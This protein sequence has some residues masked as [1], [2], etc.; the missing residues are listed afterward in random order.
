MNN[1]LKGALLSGLVFPG[2]GQL[3]LRQ[4]RRGV[5]MMLAASL[6]LLAI[7]FQAVEQAVRMLEKLNSESGLIDFDKIISAA[8]QASTSS[9]TLVYYACLLLILLCWIVSVIDAYRIGNQ[10][11]TEARSSIRTQ[12]EF[13]A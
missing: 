11:D 8:S 10:K 2:V 5:V 13:T 12:S 3:V 9:G 4:Y 1:S 6:A 7:T